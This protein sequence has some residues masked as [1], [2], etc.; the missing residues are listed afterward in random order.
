MNEN[1]NVLFE[2][3]ISDIDFTQNMK[4]KKNLKDLYDY[5]SSSVK[6]Y[7][8][9]EFKEFLKSVIIINKRIS[10]KSKELSEEEISNVTGGVNLSSHSNKILAAL[11]GGILLTSYGSEMSAR[12]F[13]VPNGMQNQVGSNIVEKN[14]DFNNINNEINKIAQNVS[15]KTKQALQIASEAAE[16]CI[17]AVLD[18]TTPKAHAQEFS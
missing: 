10:E 12:A 11:M 18:A 15:E 7:T 1:L 17:G 3:I 16:N 14:I 6:G 8:I 5:C 9:E 13:D 2:K 4:K